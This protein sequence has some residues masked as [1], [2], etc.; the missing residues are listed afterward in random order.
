MKAEIKAVG[1]WIGNFIDRHGSEIIVLTGCVIGG[2]V[3]YKLC[4]LGI[5]GGNGD[6]INTVA[7][8][9]EKAKESAEIAKESL[10]AFSELKPLVGRLND[11]F[12]DSDGVQTIVNDVTIAQMGEF[13]RALLAMPELGLKE[14]DE[15]TASMEILRA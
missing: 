4:E 7:T 3:L 14:G 2:V 5:E 12:V 13:G 10:S 15:I 1:K 8:Q 9:A 6:V 11:V